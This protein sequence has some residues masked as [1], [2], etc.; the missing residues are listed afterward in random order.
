VRVLA[1]HSIRQF[2]L[3]FPSRASPCAT[4]FWTSSTS[5]YDFVLISHFVCTCCGSNL[6]FEC[7]R[8][9]AT[10]HSY[11]V[12]W[13]L[14][15]VMFFV[16]GFAPPFQYTEERKREWPSAWE[17]SSSPADPGGRA[18]CSRSLT[19]IAVS[20]PTVGMDTCLLWL[21]CVVR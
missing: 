7:I 2:P 19:G 3:H 16:V 4:R 5:H 6:Y 1:T 14:F 9:L 20:N 13:L 10:V 8:Y 12:E 18:V 21:L 11:F 15:T 17:L